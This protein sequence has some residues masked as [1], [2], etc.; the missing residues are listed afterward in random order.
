MDD[1]M[2]RT[3][4]QHPEARHDQVADTKIMAE[5]ERAPIIYLEQDSHDQEM[6]EDNLLFPRATQCDH[7]A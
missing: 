6:T 7:D 5:R 1:Y 3:R 4:W 2:H